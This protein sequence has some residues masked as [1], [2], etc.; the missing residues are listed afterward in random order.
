[1]G[2]TVELSLGESRLRGRITEA[3]DPPLRGGENDRVERGESYVK[4]FKPM[5][6]GTIRLEKGR[7]EL[8]LRALNMPG[9]QVMD[10]R[11]MMFTRVGP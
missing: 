6:L 5:R 7:S 2:S 3:H 4:N 10:F 9:S 8:T 1:M 11:L